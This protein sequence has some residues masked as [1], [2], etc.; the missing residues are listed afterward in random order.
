MATLTK[1]RKGVALSIALVFLF[2]MANLAFAK[3][4]TFEEEYTYQASEAD[5]R[6]SSRAIALEQVKRL[7]LEKL[8]TYLES[9][10]EVKNFQ[11]TKDQITIL[12]AGVVQTEII[13][14]K[15][16]GKTYH[17]KA[18]ITADPNEVAKSIDA[19]RKDRQKSK[20]VEE[21]RKKAGEALK[22][23]E[24]LRSEIEILKNDKEKQEEYRKAIDKLNANDWFEKGFRFFILENYEE[25]IDAFSKGIELDPQIAEAYLCRGIA[26]GS[27]PNFQRAIRD[28]DAAIKLD[29]KLAPAYSMRGGSYGA[30]GIFQ[31]A[32]KDCDM[33][34]ELDPKLSLAY[35]NRGVINVALE[36]YQQ[37]LRDFNIAIELNPKFAAAYSGRGAAYYRMGDY[38]KALLSSEMAINL[39]PKDQV[40]YYYRAV[41]YEKMRDYQ[42]A[43]DNYKIAAR[44]GYK[45]AQDYLRANGIQW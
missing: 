32:L 36:K 1:Y 26:Y 16:D 31:Q 10:T 38:Q 17:L 24:R 9:E 34:I 43:I 41:I 14:D 28:Y 21:I 12:T 39:N 5:S 27:L 18:K 15:W 13:S 20:A 22:E 29:P 11:L 30:L 2:I 37:A 44:L 4:V 40:A 23:A 19:L 35:W 8:G 6:L 3:M 25:T 42:R 45:H 7:L 33:A